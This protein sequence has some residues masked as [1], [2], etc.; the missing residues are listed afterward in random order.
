M[1][2][3]LTLS[4]FHPFHSFTFN[5]TFTLT[6]SLHLHRSPSAFSLSPHPHPQLSLSPL[7]LHS[8]RSPSPLTDHPPLSPIT[9][10]LTPHRTGLAPL[11]G[12]QRAPLV[13]ARSAPLRGWR[14]PR[15]RLHLSHRQLRHLPPP[16]HRAVDGVRCQCPRAPMGHGRGAMRAMDGPR[17]PR[18]PLRPFHPRRCLCHRHHAERHAA[19]GND[20]RVTTSGPQPTTTS[21]PRVQSS[22]ELNSL[23]E[24]TSLPPT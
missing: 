24:L 17:A 9:L 14:V 21:G 2:L 15:L 23:Q 18:L 20:H 11:P 6:L 19:G 8:H 1:C 12:L 4:P 16:V 5:L 13:V 3:T 10:T 22:H 7:T